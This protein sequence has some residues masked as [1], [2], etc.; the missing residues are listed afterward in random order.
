M[1]NI[2]SELCRR[3]RCLM[4]LILKECS[5]LDQYRMFMSPPLR[6]SLYLSLYVSL[7]VRRT[8]RFD[9]GRR[10]TRGVHLLESPSLSLSCRLVYGA[11]SSGLSLQLP[12]S[13]RVYV[14]L[15]TSRPSSRHPPVPFPSCGWLGLPG[16]ATLLAWP[17]TAAGP[18]KIN[19][20]Q[21]LL[22]RISFCFFCGDWHAYR[23][24]RQ[25]QKEDEQRSVVAEWQR[26]RLSAL[27]TNGDILDTL[28]GAVRPDDLRLHSSPINL[29]DLSMHFSCV[30]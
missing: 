15:A 21:L 17:A 9:P 23:V 26:K 29:V 1:R 8:G 13:W 28:N 4:R 2:L 30:L 18:A 7:Y 25:S 19:K 11:A 12:A 3:V 6:L 24:L 14:P 22:E 16:R 10:R 20:T 5:S 27:S